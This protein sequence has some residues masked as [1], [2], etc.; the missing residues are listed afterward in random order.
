MF[1]NVQ[2]EL[3]VFVLFEGKLASYTN[4]VNEGSV[5]NLK[6]NQKRWMRISY[7]FIANSNFYLIY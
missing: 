3:Y 4:I 2:V 7:Y 5:E 6:A 1:F